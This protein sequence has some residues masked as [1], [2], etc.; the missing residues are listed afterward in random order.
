MQ[1]KRRTDELYSIMEDFLEVKYNQDSLLYILTALESA[2][3]GEPPKEAGLLTNSVKYYLEALEKELTGV[4]NRLDA[5]I[6]EEVR[7]K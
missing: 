6:L 2:Y 5:Y 3:S 7:R 4:I 1:E